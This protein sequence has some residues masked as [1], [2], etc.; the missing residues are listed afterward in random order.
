MSSMT[1]VVLRPGSFV[2]PKSTAQQSYSS[3]TPGDV[4]EV[5]VEPNCDDCGP[6]SHATQVRLNDGR[7]GLLSVGYDILPVITE[8]AK[9]K[10]NPDGK[11]FFYESK[12]KEQAK[13][14]K[15]YL[16]GVYKWDVEEMLRHFEYCRKPRPKSGWDIKTAEQ[17][18]SGMS[19]S[20]PAV[21]P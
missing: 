12:R 7:V 9:K 13:Y 14:K 17:V 3:V 19:W 10:I 16:E 15:V 8:V 11:V 18:L 2:F 20:Q 6:C 21:D 1:T 4:A 5:V